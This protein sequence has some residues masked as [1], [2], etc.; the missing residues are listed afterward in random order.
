MPID[1]PPTPAAWHAALTEHDNTVRS[2]IAASSVETE[3]AA[4]HQR[5]DA[6]MA[7]LRIARAAVAVRD[8]IL[9]EQTSALREREREVAAVQGRLETTQAHLNAIQATLA[10]RLSRRAAQALRAP[11]RLVRR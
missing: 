2:A 11:V 10:W 8:A 5:L 7:E 3:N 9:R 4:L 6:L 1:S